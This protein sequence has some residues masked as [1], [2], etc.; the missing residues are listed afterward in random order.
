MALA[1]NGARVQH[2]RMSPAAGV[3]ISVSGPAGGVALVSNATRIAQVLEDMMERACHEAASN[4]FLA[5]TAA[6]NYVLF[7]VTYDTALYLHVGHHLDATGDSLRHAVGVESVPAPIRG[8]VVAQLRLPGAPE[9]SANTYVL[10]GRGRGGGG[11]ATVLP[12]AV[13]ALSSG[14]VA[15]GWRSYRRAIAL[16]AALGGHMGVARVEPGGYTRI[17]LLLP[18]SAATPLRPGVGEG[19]GTPAEQ[20]ARLLVHAE[21]R[22]LAQAGGAPAAHAGAVERKASA[23][24]LYAYPRN[25]TRTAAAA[26]GPDAAAEPATQEACAAAATAGDVGVGRDVTASAAAASRPLVRRILYADDEAVL[27]RLVARMLERLGVP[28]DALEDG[29]EVAGALRP[30][31]D[32]ILLD[33]VMK[34]SDGAQVRVA[35]CT[36]ALS[37]RV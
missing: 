16:T 30:E 7:S 37:A 13:T 6:A 21:E 20:A 19:E 29:S 26:A 10:H 32:L 14:S 9:S 5:A 12:T 4:I 24:A 25:P 8:L 35:R 15:T 34:H 1:E 23:A 33:I 22:L 28:Y 27:R 18:G 2:H 31:H 3:S 36:T 11:T 17:W